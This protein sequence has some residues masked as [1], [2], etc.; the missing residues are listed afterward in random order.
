MPESGPDFQKVTGMCPHGNFPDSCSLCN[1]ESAQSKETREVHNVT[2]VIDLDFDRDMRELIKLAN[3]AGGHTNPD[4][5]TAK[6]DIEDWFQTLDKG[7]KERGQ[8]HYVFGIRDEGTEHLVSGGAMTVHAD[9][10]GRM[11]G[12]FRS[13]A[14]K[15]EYRG[16]GL[17]K[18]INAARMKKAEEL[19]L[20]YVDTLVKSHKPLAAMVKL[21]EGFL[22]DGG[23]REYGGFM[24]TKQL[25]EPELR[26]SQETQRVSFDHTDEIYSL[27]DEGYVGVEIDNNGERDESYPEKWTLIMRKRI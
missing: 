1:N 20:D 23:N 11:K 25:K 24:L 4:P 27:L 3:D 7:R 26:L 9:A 12:H 13:V 16:R 6:Q 2:S 17:Q 19:E 15:Q 5:V 10:K 21:K 8:T 14:T 22:L 18:E